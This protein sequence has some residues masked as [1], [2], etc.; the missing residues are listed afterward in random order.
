MVAIDHALGHGV[1]NG[2][3]EGGIQTRQLFASLADQ[4]LGASTSIL[5]AAV[6]DKTL[7]ERLGLVGDGVGRK[8]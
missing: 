1:Q 6:A 3:I 7:A 4:L 2:S 5:K 8:E